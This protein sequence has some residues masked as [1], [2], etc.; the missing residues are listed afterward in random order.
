MGDFVKIAENEND[1]AVEV[2]VEKNG[3]LLVS[4]VAA[5]YSYCK[6]PTVRMG[7]KPKWTDMCYA[8]P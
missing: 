5:S 2:P 7:T 6:L 3:T 1:D 4:N 8:N